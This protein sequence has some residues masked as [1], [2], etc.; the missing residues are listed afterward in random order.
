MS[1]GMLKD[2]QDTQLLVS[3]VADGIKCMLI[4]S[5]MQRERK[6]IVCIY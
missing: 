3:E 6:F 4:L 2:S 5:D 1:E